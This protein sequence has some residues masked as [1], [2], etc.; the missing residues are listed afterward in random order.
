[1]AG[2]LSETHTAAIRHD[3]VELGDATAI[4]VVRRPPGWFES[5]VDESIPELGPPAEL[6]EAIQRR[7]EEFAMAG[8]C[9]AG[10]H[11]AAVGETGFEEQYRAFLSEDET[12]RSE[13]ESLRERVH[14]GEHVVLV[15]TVGSDRRGHRHVLREVLSERLS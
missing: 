12:A 10:A 3:L 7:R 2:D 5:A 11:N 6:R 1:M 9:E 4:G 15:G 8:M 13:L 14:S